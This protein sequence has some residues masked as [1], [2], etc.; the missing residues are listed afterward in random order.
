MMRDSER[1]ANLNVYARHEGEITAL[2]LALRK[3]VVTLWD[4]MD[5]VDMNPDAVEDVKALLYPDDETNQRAYSDGYR[6]TV[7][8]L[9][10]RS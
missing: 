10:K 9:F 1:H 3:A 8:E 4:A 7:R 5:D 2:K 6:E